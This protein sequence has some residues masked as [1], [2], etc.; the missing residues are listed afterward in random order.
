MLEGSGYKDEA[1]RKGKGIGNLAAASLHPQAAVEFRFWSFDA[2]SDG[3]VA[4]FVLGALFACFG[5][6][7]PCPF[8]LLAAHM[9][10]QL[11]CNRFLTFSPP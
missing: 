7:G 10:A 9:T 11:E 3:V 2:F 8:P 5:G 1:R 6:I 4:P